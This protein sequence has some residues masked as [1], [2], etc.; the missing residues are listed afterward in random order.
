VNPEQIRSRRDFNRYVVDF[1][2]A[3]SYP[4]L[5][6]HLIIETAVQIKSFPTAEM[7]AGSFVYDLYK[8][9]PRIEFGTGFKQLVSE[10]REVRKPHVTCHSA[11]DNI[12]LPDC[13]SHFDRRLF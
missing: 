10:V 7:D 3:G 9:Y 12:N 6:Q 5:K 13:F 8:L 11:Q 2:S 4:F 1:Q